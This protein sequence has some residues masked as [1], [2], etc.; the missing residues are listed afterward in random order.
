MWRFVFGFAAGV[1][2]NQHYR[3]PKL[4]G[5]IE[6]IEKMEQEKRK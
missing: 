6:W 3:L 5:V 2:A 4:D 1:Y